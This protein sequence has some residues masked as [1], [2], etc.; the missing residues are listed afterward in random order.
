MSDVP[1]PTTSTAPQ[2]LSSPLWGAE[3]QLE[4]EVYEVCRATIVGIGVGRH[5]LFSIFGIDSL[6]IVVLCCVCVCVCMCVCVYVCVGGCGCVYVCAHM[7][8]C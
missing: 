7:H 4:K 3:A 5:G 6:A 8:T 2:V 1:G